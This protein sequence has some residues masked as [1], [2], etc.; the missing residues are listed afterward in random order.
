MV[1]S[2]NKDENDSRSSMSQNFMVLSRE[3]VTIS[4]R[5]SCAQSM[6]YILEVC[7]SIRV[8]GREP[9]WCLFQPEANKQLY[10][11]TCPSIPD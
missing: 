7:A 9:F 1:G 2:C 11:G 4:E 3:Q 8:M 5:E 10:E 6:P